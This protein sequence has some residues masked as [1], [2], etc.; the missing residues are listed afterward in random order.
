MDLQHIAIIM[1]GN[2]RWA[3][4]RGLPRSAG[5]QEGANAAARI[6][7]TL[8]K[9][10][11]PFLTLY[12]L[13]TENLFRPQKELDALTSLMRKYLDEEVPRLLKHNVRLKV[14]GDRSLLPSDLRKKMAAAEAE[15]AKDFMMTLSLAICYGG[16]DD[17]VRAIKKLA[18][19]VPLKKI[20]PED[21]DSAL[22]TAGVPDPDLIIRTGGEYRLSNFLT[23]QSAYSEL[24]FTKTLWPDFTAA[25][26]KRAM[27]KFNITERRFGR[28]DDAVGDRTTSA[29]IKGKLR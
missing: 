16:R 6:T 14:I 15:T 10:G 21:I 12:A 8:R 1:D 17:V 4:K 23:W 20:G 26:L 9:M 7:R 27:K 13:S 2:G 28:T 22:D 24:Y 29:K 25:H 11:V 3:K 5:H 18:D 19:R